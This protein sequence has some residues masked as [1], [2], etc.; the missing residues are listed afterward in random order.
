M[1][2]FVI[3]N[4]PHRSKYNKIWNWHTAEPSDLNWRHIQAD[5]CK[6]WPRKCDSA[7]LLYKVLQNLVKNP[8][9][10]VAWTSVDV[11][12]WERRL[13]WVPWCLL[14]IP[15]VDTDAEMQDSSGININHESE[16]PKPTAVLIVKQTKGTHFWN[17]R[18]ND[19]SL[20]YFV[21]ISHYQNVK[22]WCTWV[23]WNRTAASSALRTEK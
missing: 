23:K 4:L 3:I 1:H 7:K 13:K 12:L 9:S 10:A 5:V 19:F 8:L 11:E 2:L 20:K 21:F 22:A 15:L 16:P 14:A 6:Y 18:I 17:L